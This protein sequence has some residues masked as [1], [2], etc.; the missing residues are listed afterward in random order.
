[1]EN[2]LLFPIKGGSLPHL[3]MPLNF[4]YWIRKLFSFSN[5]PLFFRFHNSSS[6][7][8]P[9][10]LCCS[11]FTSPCSSFCLQCCVFRC[12]DEILPTHLPASPHSP[13]S[14]FEFKDLIILKAIQETDWAVLP[15]WFQLKP[16]KFRL[17]FEQSFTVFI[18]SCFIYFLVHHLGNIRA[19]WFF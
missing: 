5:S 9:S 12:W 1:M 15:Q 7:A 13:F 11:G 17:N 4:R 3:L 18:S 19:V 10:A 16:T 2:T 14:F 6:V 8:L